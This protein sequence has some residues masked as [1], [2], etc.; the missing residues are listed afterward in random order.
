M[1]VIDGSQGEGGGQ[2]FR[3]S[4][5]MSMQSG[6]PV[7]IDNIRAR[8]SK[9][10]LLRQHLACLRA[11]S[12]ICSADVQGAEL[13]SDSVTFRPGKVEAGDYHFSIGSA[14]STSLVFQTVFLPLMF[15]D[16][17]SDIRLEGGTHNGHAPSFDFIA[18]SFL[19]VVETM[20]YRAEAK[21]DR[22]GF[23]PAGGGAWGVKVGKMNGVQP[24]SLM[25]R[26][27][28]VSQSAV[29][30]SS[31]IPEHIT[32]RELAQIQKKCLWSGE[33]LE[34]N[35]VDSAG[36]GNIVSLRVKS[37]QVIEVVEVVGE[38]QLSAERVAGRAI[39]AV[40]RYLDS[41]VPVGEYLADQLLLPMVLGGGGQFRTMSPS[42]HFETN[43]EIIKQFMDVDIRVDR[44]NEHAWRVAI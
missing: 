20:G 42:L 34:Q 22:Y 2:V 9:P 17:E 6:E 24:L 8:R 25:E 1:I 15:A 43:V 41:G 39:K 36:P 10:G 11:A 26:G 35:I 30:T 28:I 33:Q 40:K 44:E 21:L 29:A 3:T 32:E 12:E 38:K 7:R 14:G 23:Y 37:E 4:L 27:E 31:H 19:P 13:G 5:T 16:K 18:S